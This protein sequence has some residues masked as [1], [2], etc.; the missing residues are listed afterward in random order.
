MSQPAGK[1]RPNPG[2]GLSGSQQVSW[3][4]VHLFVE[5]LVAQ[6]NAGPIPGAGT[7][8]WAALP[9]GDPRKLLALVVAG[10]H[11]VLRTEIAQELRA[12]AAEDIW[13]GE[14][15]TQVASQVARRKEIDRYKEAS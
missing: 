14:D 4:R 2:A 1:A 7:P 13:T 10:E 6:T 8:A 12:H 15:W 9:D 3:W 5:A 11:H